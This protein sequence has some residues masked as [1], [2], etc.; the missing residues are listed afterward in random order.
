MI[1]PS[2]RTGLYA[3]WRACERLGVRPPDV[4]DEWVE[5]DIVTQT[6]IL[7]YGRVRD[8]EESE[9]MASMTKLLLR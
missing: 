1:W 8:Y 3:I 6:Y 7:A 5:N 4:K 9:S 2:N